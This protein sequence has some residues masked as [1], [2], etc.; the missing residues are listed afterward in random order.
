MSQTPASYYN[1]KDKTGCCKIFSDDIRTGPWK[2]GY[3]V[4]TL[5]DCRHANLKKYPMPSH[6][7]KHV[8]KV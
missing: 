5:W 7:V 6:A 2:M 3:I 8:H 4:V 1:K